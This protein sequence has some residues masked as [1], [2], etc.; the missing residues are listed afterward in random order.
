[1]ANIR[2]RML[3]IKDGTIRE[4]QSQYKVYMSLMASISWGMSIINI[5]ILY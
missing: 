1:M 2:A 4:Y 5:L 3:E